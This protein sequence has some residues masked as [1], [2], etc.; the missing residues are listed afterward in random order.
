MLK[1]AFWKVMRDAAATSAAVAE[2]VVNVERELPSAE[3]AAVQADEAL[4]SLTMQR[5][6]GHKVE[7]RAFEE[8]QERRDETH[9]RVLALRRAS[10]EL[11]AQ[12]TKA[13]ERETAESL[14]KTQGE[15]QRIEGEIIAVRAEALGLAARLFAVL[16]RICPVWFKA[17]G[18][19]AEPSL[20]SFLGGPFGIIAANVDLRLLYRITGRLP[21]NDNLANDPETFAVLWAAFEQ[22]GLLET[23]E[24]APGM[25][26]A[27]PA[28]CL[29][30]CR[31][32]LEDQLK[33][34][35]R[36]NPASEAEVVLAR[37]RAQ[38]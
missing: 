18:Q 13:T 31:V 17:P 10:E 28:A 16:T 2:E 5:E 9:L 4:I 24:P 11:R 23:A 20:A 35:K 27:P 22:A 7:A 15:F 14:T 26:P 29:Y 33:T 36:L 1:L 25:T 12:L 30:A 21:R 3:A 38:G 8:A 32:A 37:V 19:Y 34:L 6:G